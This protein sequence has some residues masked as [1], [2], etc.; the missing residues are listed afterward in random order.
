MQRFFFVGVVNVGDGNGGEEVEVL[1]CS[2]LALS[3]YVRRKEPNNSYKDRVIRLYPFN[4]FF[5]SIIYNQINRFS[6]SFWSLKREVIPPLAPNF[7]DCFQNS[8]LHFFQFLFSRNKTWFICL[9]RT[10]DAFF[11][12]I[13]FS[14]FAGFPH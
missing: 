10:R 5:L 3:F 7:W 13:I 14:F 2:L 1:G 11:L 9:L 6:F 8:F 4:F 12:L